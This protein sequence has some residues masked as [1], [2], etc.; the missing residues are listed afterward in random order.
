MAVTA[1]TPHSV[2]HAGRRWPVV[3]GIPFLRA[4][5]EEL[6]REALA[7]LDAGDRVAALALLLADQDD[8]WD[9]DAAPEADLR[10]LARDPQTVTLREA[11]EALRWARV[12][13]YFAH[14]WS[15]PTF[16][17]GLAL[18]R[19]H[20][21]A[22]RSAFELACG[23]GHHLRELSL[24][25]VAVSGGD[26]VFAKLWLARH[27]V[28]PE[29]RLACFDAAHPWPVA[30][31]HDLVL[32]HDAFYF[33]EPK[34]AVLARLR[35]LRGGGRGLLLISH[36][37]NADRPG[38]SAGHAISRARL[39]GLFPAVLAYAD[40]ELTRALAEGR[41]PLPGRLDGTEA[42]AVAEGPGL[43]APQSLADGVVL[44][45]PGAALRRNPLYAE[46][47]ARRFPSERYAS[48][49][50]ARVTYPAVSD[51]PARAVLDASTAHWALRRE[52][53][54][55]PERW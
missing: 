50:G 52:L 18:T 25:G 47:G 9:G 23:I 37:H 4:G 44:P 30:D 21:M 1:D 6:A 11:M 49:Y 7:A 53:L 14:R 15:D 40:E 35:G 36:I 42:F 32:C 41:A 46:G 29:A 31:R 55:L 43:G 26:V 5:R 12:A 28:C 13:D 34:Q 33:L 17:A 22:P 45:P 54:H 27:F 38:F 20:W 8:W 19:A 48:E 16:L 2:V 10:A 51:A 24:R 3:D 39:A